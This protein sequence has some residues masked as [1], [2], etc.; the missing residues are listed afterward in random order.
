MPQVTRDAVA[1][2]TAA[3][4]EILGDAAF[5]TTWAEGRALSFDAAITIAVEQTGAGT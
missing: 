1:L 2:H 3:S 5:A 4:R